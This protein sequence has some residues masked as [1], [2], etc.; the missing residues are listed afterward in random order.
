MALEALKA[1]VSLLLQG[2]T[3][4]P[5]DLHQLQ[6]S[7]REKISEFSALGHQPPQDLVD[8]EKSLR[9]SLIAGND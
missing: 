8:L 9:E 5:E 6:E 2:A 1:S 7:V 3:E 4:A